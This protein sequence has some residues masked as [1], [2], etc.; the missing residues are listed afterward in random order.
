MFVAIMQ[1]CKKILGASIVLLFITNTYADVLSSDNL[2]GK[3][4]DQIAIDA[5]KI[6]APIISNTGKAFVTENKLGFD[7]LETESNWV[8]ETFINDITKD[9]LVLDVGSGYGTLTRNALS[10]G[11]T[12]VSNDLSESQLL[13][14][15]KHVL[16]I[17]RERLYLND[18]D[19]KQIVFAENSFNLIIFHRVLH[20]FKGKE[21]EDILK[22]SHAWLKP[23]GK[24]YIVMMSKDH[25]AFRD[26]IVYDSSK[27]WPGE[28]LVVVAQHLPEQ[29][30]ALPATLHVVSVDTLQQQ[31]EKIGFKI[32][33]GDFV[34]L[35]KVGTGNRDGKEAVGIIATKL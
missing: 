33:K 18:R 28:D 1:Y 17:D 9:M 14:N 13:Y 15:L 32:E 20:F 24:I 10:K 5:N 27:E 7:V 2:L 25:I 3:R 16:P 31:L 12:V 4:A 34:A 26:K 29:A 30:Y 19:I 22:K 23:G 35:K 6:P 21:I 11:A 8:I